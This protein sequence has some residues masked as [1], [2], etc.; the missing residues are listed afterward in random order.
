MKIISA[1]LVGVN[2]KYNGNSNFDPI[3][4]EMVAKGKAIPL[5]PEQLGGCSTPRPSCEIIGGTGRDVIKGRAKVLTKDGKDVT[6][7][8]IKGAEETLKIAKLVKAKKAILK[9]GSPSC[10]YGTIYDGTFSNKKIQGNGVAA[11]LLAENGIEI[12]TVEY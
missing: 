9:S 10:G 8:F 4:A 1:C 12:E 3:T 11:E 7:A 6:K 5:C 2:C